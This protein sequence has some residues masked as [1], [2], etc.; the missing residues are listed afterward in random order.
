MGAHHTCAA[1]ATLCDPL[2]IILLAVMMM[3]SGGAHIC[4]SSAIRRHNAFR[5]PLVGAHIFVSHSSAM[6]FVSHSSARIFVICQLLVS[7][8]YFVS[9]SSAYLSALYYI[10]LL[11][12]EVVDSVR[13]VAGGSKHK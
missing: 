1:G 8:I 13:L 3:P 4:H 11:G 7:N 2:L 10:F 9:H 6:R 5:Q 12:E